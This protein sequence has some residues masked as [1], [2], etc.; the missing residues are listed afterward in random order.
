M[1]HNRIFIESLNLSLRVEICSYFRKSINLKLIQTSLP[2]KVPNGS[3]RPYFLS[4]ESLYYIV[5]FLGF[6]LPLLQSAFFSIS[7]FV[8]CAKINFHDYAEIVKNGEMVIPNPGYTI[9]HSVT[10]N[11]STPESI[12]YKGYINIKSAYR[13]EKLFIGGSQTT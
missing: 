6:N 3:F 8:F 9:W 5:D 4:Y 7:V 2:A 1:S 10:E 13:G 12:N 11:Q